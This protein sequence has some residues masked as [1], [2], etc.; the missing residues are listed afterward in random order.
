MSVLDCPPDVLCAVLGCAEAESVVAFACTSSAA[1]SFVCTNRNGI[2][3]CRPT[4][5]V[6]RNKIASAVNALFPD[7]PVFMAYYGNM[8]RSENVNALK[9]WPVVVSHQTVTKESAVH[10]TCEDHC[11]CLRSKRGSVMLSDENFE[12]QDVTL[13][14]NQL[15]VPI[16]TTRVI[17][18]VGGHVVGNLSGVVIRALAGSA[19]ELDVMPH[20]LGSNFLMGGARYHETTVCIHGSE[21]L[22][23]TVVTSHASFD[24]KPPRDDVIPS[25]AIRVAPIMSEDAEPLVTDSWYMYSLPFARILGLYVL[26]EHVHTGEIVNDVLDTISVRSVSWNS[27]PTRESTFPAH[28]LRSTGDIGGMQRGYTL[29]LT[30]VNHNFSQTCTYF[31]LRVW[32]GVDVT[33][34]RVA[35]AHSQENVMCMRGGMIGPIVSR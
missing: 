12:E 29:P 22:R 16:T 23:A 11:A 15:V 7:N 20:T 4:A 32:P 2:L 8:W 31:C 24:A 34:Y 13:T 5:F 25:L 1:A 10:C 28:A 33:Q 9:T 35:F 30:G 26:I 27:D 6:G 19:P 14:L 3:A 18:C 21:Q 17:L